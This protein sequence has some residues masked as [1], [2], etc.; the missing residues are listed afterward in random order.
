MEDPF[1]PL[2][3]EVDQ[4]I[5]GISSLYKQWQELL[6]SSNTATSDEFKWAMNELRSGIQNIEPDLTDLEQTITIAEKN[7]AKFGIDAA[8]LEN[9]KAIVAKLKR[10][11]SKV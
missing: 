9:R 4:S 5:Q 7:Q 6:K 1:Y 3:E 8:E 11:R 10:E 2:K